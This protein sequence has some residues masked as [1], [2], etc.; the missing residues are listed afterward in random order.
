MSR[1]NSLTLA[2]V[3]AAALA[4]QQETMQIRHR[5]SGEVVQTLAGNSLRE[6]DLENMDLIEANLA[7]EDLRYANFR[8]T[9]LIAA[10]LRN[11][12]LSGANLCGADLSNAVLDGAKLT[13]AQYDEKTTWP[14]DFNPREFGAVFL[15]SAASKKAWWKFW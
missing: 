3:R 9:C 8:H 11:A 13:D 5:Y 2:R 4:T 12:D 6:A 10:V 14:T 15:P 7:D 1:I